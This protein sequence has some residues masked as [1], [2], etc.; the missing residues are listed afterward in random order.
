M[1]TF[2]QAESDMMVSSSPPSSALKT[3]TVAMRDI[4][5]SVAV[6]FQ[7]LGQAGRRKKGERAKA[8][9]APP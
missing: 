6:R 5:R 4:H 1:E 7:R 2:V 9:I 8:A 3:D